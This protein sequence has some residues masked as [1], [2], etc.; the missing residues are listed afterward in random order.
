MHL[1]GSYLLSSRM[2]FV[3]TCNP[4]LGAYRVGRFCFSQLDRIVNHSAPRKSAATT[5]AKLYRGEL[6]QV[7]PPRLDISKTEFWISTQAQWLYWPNDN[8][9][10]LALWDPKTAKKKLTSMP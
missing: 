2:P 6:K 3:N 1:P 10:E 4:L 9:S 8:N 5:K 7:S